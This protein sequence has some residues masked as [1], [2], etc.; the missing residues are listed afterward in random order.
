MPN[1]HFVGYVDGSTAFLPAI[2]IFVQPSW[3][4]GL[5]L[6]LL[7]AA[8][9]AIPMVA[10]RVGATDWAVRDSV[11]ATLINAGDSFALAEGVMRLAHNQ[12]RRESMGKAARQ[13]FDEALNID[14]MQRTYLELYHR[15]QSKHR[16]SPA[17]VGE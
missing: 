11:E 17:K 1:I 9:A 10:T 2:D 13:R 8:R 14:A 16:K 6:A 5:S 7:E 15:V 12:S 4:E 3:S